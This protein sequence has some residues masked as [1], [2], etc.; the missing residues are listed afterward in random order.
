MKKE[1]NHVWD[2][3]DKKKKKKHACRLQGNAVC[4][5][6]QDRRDRSQTVENFRSP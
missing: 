2:H 4:V 1:G 6:M 3:D 5:N